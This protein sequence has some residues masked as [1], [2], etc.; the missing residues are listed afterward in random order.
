M[1]SQIIVRGRLRQRFARF[2][3][4]GAA[5]V[6]AT[7]ASAA[8]TCEDY[9]PTDT[10]VSGGGV[11]GRSVAA[12]RLAHMNPFDATHFAILAALDPSARIRRELAEALTMRFRL[13]GDGFVLDHLVAD[14]DPGVRAAALRA[15]RVRGY[16][17]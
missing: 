6:S 4:S 12:I 10:R 5:V 13:V 11:G 9:M 8:N 15:C 1:K 14:S 16:R 3:F 17:R 2:L 7:P